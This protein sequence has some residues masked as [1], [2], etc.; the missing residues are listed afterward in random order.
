MDKTLCA[1][2]LW[3]VCAL[4]L[5]GSH[6]D[7]G[8]AQLLQRSWG[9]L[10][11]PT[12]PLINLSHASVPRNVVTRKGAGPTRFVAQHLPEHVHQ[13]PQGASSRGRLWLLRCRPSHASA[14]RTLLSFGAD[15][16]K[17]GSPKHQSFVGTRALHMLTTAIP[18]VLKHQRPVNTTT[19]H[20]F[21]LYHCDSPQATLL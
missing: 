6:K 8:E 5:Q 14:I 4:W 18:A 20:M 7:G 13:S 9:T 15:G 19:A 3:R 1:V 11:Y 17:A 2:S 16:V 21:T 12:Q 10:A